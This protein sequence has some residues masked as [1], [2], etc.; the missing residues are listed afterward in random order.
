M[1]PDYLSTQWALRAAAERGVRAVPVQHHHA[2]LAACL[3]EHRVEGRR[4]A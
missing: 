1:H 2:H 3:A 4:S